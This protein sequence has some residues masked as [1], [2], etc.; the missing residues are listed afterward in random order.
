MS[1]FPRRWIL[2]AVPAIGSHTALRFIKE[3]FVTGEIEI[4]EAAPVLISMMHMV[5]A[6]REV[7]TLVEASQP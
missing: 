4:I 6:D 7:L 2:E 5:T 1:V 3:K